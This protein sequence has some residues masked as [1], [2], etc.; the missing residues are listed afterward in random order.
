MLE[1]PVLII[2]LFDLK[3]TTSDIPRIEK[4]LEKAKNKKITLIPIRIEFIN[5]VY[6]RDVNLSSYKGMEYKGETDDKRAIRS[7]VASV[8]TFCKPV[9]SGR[10]DVIIYHS[11]DYAIEATILES[12]IKGQQLQSKVL[13]TE[14]P[15]I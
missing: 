12:L 14:Q 2:A 5:Q 3:N 6:F 7:F 9:L 13:K 1:I 15:E 4:M 8:F 10:E 11:S